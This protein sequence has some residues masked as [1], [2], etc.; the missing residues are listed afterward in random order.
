[1]CCHTHKRTLILLAHTHTLSGRSGQ[2]IKPRKACANSKTALR[3]F[4]HTAVKTTHT[5][6]APMLARIT[7]QCWHRDFLLVLLR[8]RRNMICI[9]ICIYVF[10]HIC[11]HVCLYTCDMYIYICI[12]IYTHVICVYTYV[13]V[14]MYTYIYVD[15]YVCLYV[16]IYVCMYVSTSLDIHLYIYIYIHRY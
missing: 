11:R 6:C 2:K 10:I 7:V 5:S 1:M 9:C 14:Y 15:M 12:C 8:P 4:S 16:H 13:Y 3:V